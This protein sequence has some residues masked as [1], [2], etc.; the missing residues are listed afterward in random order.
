MSIP[1]AAADKQFRE[2]ADRG[3]QDKILHREVRDEQADR[4][5]LRSDNLLSSL[6]DE[7]GRVEQGPG[8]P[9]Q[10]VRYQTGRQLQQRQQQLQ[11]GPAA[12]HPFGGQGDREA[13]RAAKGEEER[14]SRTHHINNILFTLVERQAKT[15]ECVQQ[16]LKEKAV[17]DKEKEGRNDLSLPANIHHLHGGTLRGFQKSEMVPPELRTVTAPYLPGPVQGAVRWPGTE[18]EPPSQSDRHPASTATTRWTATPPLPPRTGAFSGPPPAVAAVQSGGINTVFHPL[19]LQH[20]NGG[21]GTVEAGSSSIPGRPPSLLAEQL[22][23]FRFTAPSLLPP[24]PATNAGS[25]CNALTQFV[26]N[27]MSVGVSILNTS[28]QSQRDLAEAEREVVLAQQ[29]LAEQQR[30]ADQQ[31]LAAGQPVGPVQEAQARLQQWSHQEAHLQ[32]QQSVGQ[33]VSRQEAQRQLQQLGVQP[34]VDGGETGEARVP[35][36]PPG[37]LPLPAQAA[38]GA[39]GGGVQHQIQ[40]SPPPHVGGAGVG[41]RVGGGSAP[42]PP[43]AGP[44]PH[45]QVSDPPATVGTTSPTRTTGTRES[46]PQAGAVRGEMSNIPH[47]TVPVLNFPP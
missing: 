29:R 16:L 43:S 11:A 45:P 7:L 14:A 1:I 3:V 40:A 28:T 33:T 25:H 26:S 20:G 44:A 39:G 34:V 10:V 32:L 15:Q 2:L 22:G 8:N 13:E 19:P 5:D 18:A 42:S 31:R 38:V 46:A 6:A 37:Y 41:G 17:G 9:N 24:A 36:P 21:L 27:G 12:R 35:P 4:V 47:L 30:L 23:G